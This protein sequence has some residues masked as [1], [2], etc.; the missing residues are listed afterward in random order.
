[1]LPETEATALL[2][3]WAAAGAGASD[4]ATEQFVTPRYDYL[5]PDWQRCGAEQT[6]TWECPI[7]L[8]IDRARTRLV[9]VRYRPGAPAETRLVLHPQGAAEPI[10]VEPASLLIAD[11]GALR[12]VAFRQPT[13]QLGVLVDE[14]HHRVLIGA[15]ALL[16]STFT[17][18]MFLDGRFAEGFEK[19]DDRRGYRG[20][21]VVTWRVRLG[22][23]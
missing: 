13:D 14:P 9:S 22:A 20:E 5:V 3:H 16:R 4:A 23:T 21:R 2:D 18:L 15:P 12:E 19:T 8:P 17:R 11:A 7:G 6:G 1:V 10:E